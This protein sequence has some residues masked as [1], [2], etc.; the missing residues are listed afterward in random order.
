M[1]ILVTI[2]PPRYPK[3]QCNNEHHYQHPILTQ[4]QHTTSFTIH[5]ITRFN[6][7]ASVPLDSPIPLPELA[8]LT[9]TNPITLQRILRHCMLNHIF[10]EPT[11]GLIAHT[12]TSLLLRTTPASIAWASM[13]PD[14]FWP[15]TTR[16]VDAIKKWPQ[17]SEPTETAVTLA[18]GTDSFYLYLG[19]FPQK[20]A[21]FGMAMTGFSSGPGL[22]FETLATSYPWQDLPLGSTVVDVGSGIGFVSVAIAQ[23]HTSLKFVCQDL[24]ST[25][26]A[27]PESVPVDVKDRIT[28]QGHDFL[29]PNPVAGAAVY[30][31]RFI[32]HNWSDVYCIRILQALIPALKPGS[33]I[34]IN[35]TALPEHGEMSRWEER[36]LRDLDMTMLTLLNAREREVA[37]FRMLFEK[38]DTRFK[39]VG[40]RLPEGSKMW[41][42][43]AMWEPEG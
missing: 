6:I 42:I 25:V 15:I 16:A 10:A 29:T 20:A 26:A 23:A 2:Y 34:L 31:F 32:F 28:F 11:K 41:E 4:S 36:T 8:T 27:G 39:W 17:S 30:F 14:D 24:P 40:A 18:H 38:S 21:R 5:Y 3:S 35:D 22:E 19:K 1:F 9:N 37:E 13:M 33:R 7:A 43:E 12:P